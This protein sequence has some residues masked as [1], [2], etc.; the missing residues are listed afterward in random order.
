MELVAR[1]SKMISGLR[2]KYNSKHITPYSL[3]EKE[4]GTGTKN[5]YHC[6]PKGLAYRQ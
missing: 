2:A 4:Y 6:R 1:E 3:L 5:I